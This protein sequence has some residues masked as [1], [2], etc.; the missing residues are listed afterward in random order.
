MTMPYRTRECCDIYYHSTHTLH[1]YWS[2][3]RI[4]RVNQGKKTPLKLSH[5]IHIHHLMFCSISLQFEQEKLTMGVGCSV[6]LSK[7][8]EIWTRKSGRQDRCLVDSKADEG[9]SGTSR[10]IACFPI[11]LLYL[12][13]IILISFSFLAQY[14]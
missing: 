9:K 2:I 8:D 10:S 3:I 1:S 5:G 11:C 7:R 14:I 12:W 13:N 4:S 6:V